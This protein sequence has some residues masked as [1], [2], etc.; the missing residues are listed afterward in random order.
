MLASRCARTLCSPTRSAVSF[1]P[2][3]AL[4]SL[5]STSW[6][7]QSRF[8]TTTPRRRK[9]EPREHTIEQ[10][11]A[12]KSDIPEGIKPESVQKA[13][14][15]TPIPAGPQDPLL[16]EKTVSNQEQRKA[17]WAIIK[18]MSVY[19]W[20][21]VCFG[22]TSYG[23]LRYC[24]LYLTGRVGQ[25]RHKSTGWSISGLAD[26]SKGSHSPSFLRLHILRVVYRSS[27]YKFPST[28]RAS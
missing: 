17:D 25:P 10:A 15:A 7:C 22:A 18:E 9:D 26:R 6:H 28:S 19:L 5:P 20:P 24:C 1:R 11:K 3:Q 4:S 8:L 14:P 13:K 27:M 21:K 2:S 23:L 12:Q 16:A